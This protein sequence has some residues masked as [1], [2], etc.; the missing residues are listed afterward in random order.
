MMFRDDLKRSA[1]RFVLVI[2]IVNLFADATYEG[3]RGISGPFLGSLGTSAAVVGIVAGLG[4]LLGYCLRSVSGYLADKTHK[5][6]TFIFAGYAMN[7]LAVPALALAGAWPMA[8]GL[9]IAERTGR[10]IRRPSIEALIADAGN[11]IGH[12]WVFGFNEALDQ[13]GAT[14]GP[15]ATALVL[16]LRG[17]FH[18]AFAFL[19]IPALLCLGTLSA[20]RF[21]RS[22]ESEP[23]APLPANPQNYPKAYWMYAAAGA[24]FAAG[25]ADFSLVAFHFRKANVLSQA[26]VPVVYSVAMASGAIASVVMGRLLDRRGAKISVAAFLLSACAPPLVFLGQFTL[27]LAG[28]VLWGIGLGAQDSLLKALLSRVIPN[29]RSSAFGLFDTIFGVSWFVGSATM[30][31]LYSR[32]LTTLVAFSVVLQLAA[33][34]FLGRAIAVSRP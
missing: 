30:G 19:L 2:G 11:K 16:Y 15:L 14:I 20:A 3:A 24:C 32:S 8:A 5:Y 1:F 12:G 34:P 21:L 33:L 9:L 17:G 4:E 18:Q 26:L 7:M 10:A 29:T 25:F 6:W 31:L 22:R 27:V 23:S 28:A 13:T